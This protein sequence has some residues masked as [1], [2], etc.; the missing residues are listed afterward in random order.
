MESYFSTVTVFAILFYENF[1][2]NFPKLLEQTFFMEH[3]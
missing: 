1:R 3:L 2:E